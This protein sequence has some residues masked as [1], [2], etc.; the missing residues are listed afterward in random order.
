MSTP[1]IFLSYAREDKP[2]VDEVYKSLKAAGLTPWMDVPPEPFRGEGIPLGVEWE[3]YVRNKLRDAARVLAFLSSHSVQTTGFVHREYRLA[4]GF[5]AERPSGQQW[6]IPVRLDD[7]R[8]PEHRVDGVSL[9][10]LSWYD[11]TSENLP[12]LIAYLREALPGTDQL[13]AEHFALIHSCWRAAKHDARFNQSVYRFDVVLDG[14]AAL[15]DRVEGITYSAAACLADVSKK[16]SD[17]GS[18]F[19]LKELTGLT[20]S[21]ERKFI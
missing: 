2:R 9:G 16:V 18:G 6:L 15:L 17:R 10:Q 20:C 13:S 8:P 12:H 4:L 5:L 1:F 14:P 7:C 19:G 21:Y 3:P 11:L